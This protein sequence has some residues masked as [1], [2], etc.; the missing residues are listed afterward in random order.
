MLKNKG[1]PR[2]MS[3]HFDIYI[4]ILVIH[5]IGLH[6]GITTVYNTLEYNILLLLFEVKFLTLEIIYL[7][8]NIQTVILT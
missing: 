4:L 3:Y 8:G 5:R 7:N 6:N 1:R 2:A